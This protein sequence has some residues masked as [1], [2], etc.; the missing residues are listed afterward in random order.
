M[1]NMAEDDIEHV[2]CPLCSSTS[3]R[4]YDKLNNWN[5]VACNTCDLKFTNPRPTLESLPTYYSEEYFQDERHVGKFYD[6]EGGIKKADT[7]PYINRIQDVENFSKQRGKLLEL[8]AA[9]GGFINVLQKRGWNVKGIDISQDAV[10]FGR[11]E[12]NLDMFCGH[13]A[14][15]PDNEMF[16]VI[17][18]YQTLEHVPDPGLVIEKSYKILNTNGLFIAEIPNI[19]SFDM[20][21]SKERK[22]LSY[23]LPRHLNHFSEKVLTRHLEQNGFRIIHVNRYYPNFIL[24]LLQNKQKPAVARS[25]Q[26]ETKVKSNDEVIPMMKYPTGWKQQLLQMNSRLFPGWR[27]TVIAQKNG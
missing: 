16:D 25:S 17:C 23:D 26:N 2:S 1:K 24:S 13:F 15:F 18:M 22:R 19:N 7:S 20:K 8:G 12:L 5:I 14:D 6:K 21:I 10:D 9:R 3:H 11:K 4:F 27:F